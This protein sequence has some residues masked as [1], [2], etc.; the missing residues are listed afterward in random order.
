MKLVSQ[1]QG[2]EDVFGVFAR[3]VIARAGLRNLELLTR[4]KKMEGPDQTGSAFAFV[5]DGF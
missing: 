2:Q 3:F 1:G 5:G 4:S